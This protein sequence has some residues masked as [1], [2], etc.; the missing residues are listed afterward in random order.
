MADTQ[1]LNATFFAFRKRERGGVLLMATLTYLVIA[2]G[3]FAIFGY[4]NFGAVMEYIRWAIEMGETGAAGT[5]TPPAS[6]MA[7]GPAMF[8]FQIVMYVV[9][10]AYEAAC[11]RWMVRG[12]TGGL[13]GFAFGGD[14]WRVYFTY[15][16]WFFVMI[17]FGLVFVLLMGG[18]A[19]SMAIGA[20]YQGADMSGAA[21]AMPII[22]LILL[23]AMLYFAVRVAPAAATSIALRRFA[24][25]DAWKVTRGRFW[26]LLGAYVLLFLIF[27]VAYI[28]VSMAGGVALVAGIMGQGGA[29]ESVET[30]EQMG[31]LLSSPGIWVPAVLIYGLIGVCA[32]VLQVALY[33]VNARAASLALEEG[34]I[35]A[36]G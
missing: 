14:T 15:W 12:E 34:K 13:F 5:M 28:V 2:V 36:A 27:I 33:G 10:A 1:A 23:L 19:G 6:V 3:G 25:F 20:A 32:L 30:P 8:L 4:L 11:L 16:V 29:F 7:L 26:A 21:V 18:F 24:F 31:A 9:A 17:G 35:G 22:C